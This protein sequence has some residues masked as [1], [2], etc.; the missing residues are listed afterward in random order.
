MAASF[1]RF[2]SDGDKRV[3]T[4]ITG[5]LP[6]HFILNLRIIIHGIRVDSGS[7]SKGIERKD[8]LQLGDALVCESGV[9]ES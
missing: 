1:S 8:M 5:T 9:S 2:K 6:K 3:H 7:I 4:A